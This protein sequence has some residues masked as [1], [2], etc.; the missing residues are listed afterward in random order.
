MVSKAPARK[1]GLSSFGDHHGLLGGQFVRALGRVVDDVAAGG[2]VAEPFA[3]VPLGGAGP[4]GQRGRRDRPGA[5]HR[6]VQAQPVAEVQQ[7]P[8]D[9]RAH[10]DHRLSDERLELR[11]VDGRDVGCRHCCLRSSAQVHGGPEW[12]PASAAMRTCGRADE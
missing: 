5:G 1:T 10:V 3:D 2:L 7:Q 12:M 8:G 9:G 11:L 4:L 6:L